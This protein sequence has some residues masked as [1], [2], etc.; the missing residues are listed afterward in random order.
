MKKLLRTVLKQEL[1]MKIFP[2]SL[3][4]ISAMQLLRKEI[5]KS[6]ELRKKLYEEDIS[7]YV[8]YFTHKQVAEILNH[9]GITQEE[10]EL[11]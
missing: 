4:A 11:L 10:Y 1:A 3:S 8:H 2:N 9:F 7:I 5:R 6:P